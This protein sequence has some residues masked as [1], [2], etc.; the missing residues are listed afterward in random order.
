ME[1]FQIP[2]LVCRDCHH[3][4]TRPCIDR[5]ASRSVFGIESSSGVTLRTT[6]SFSARQRKQVFVPLWFLTFSCARLSFA[7]RALSS[8]AGSQRSFKQC[9]QSSGHR[10]TLEGEQLA[11]S[12]VCM[13]DG[14]PRASPDRLQHIAWA[15]AREMWLRCPRGCGF[16]H[17]YVGWIATHG[18][19][20]APLHFAAMVRDRLR[21]DEDYQAWLKD[22]VDQAR[23]ARMARKRQRMERAA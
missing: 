15:E 19:G 22:E 18:Y 10:L 5:P 11:G 8:S 23:R 1:T 12:E 3:H 4:W 21:A 7:T 16:P 9:P 20:N 17:D 2:G 14:K 6:T 13:T